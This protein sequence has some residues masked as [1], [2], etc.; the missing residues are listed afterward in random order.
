MVPLYGWARGLR[1]KT[2]SFFPTM[3]E[4]F[5]HSNATRV[6]LHLPP[7]PFELQVIRSGL[8]WL[9]PSHHADRRSLRLVENGRRGD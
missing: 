6:W 3:K 2:L 1:V 7:F 5:G 9:R 8:E 4:E